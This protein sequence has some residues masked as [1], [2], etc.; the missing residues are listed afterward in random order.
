MAARKTV[1]LVRKI[2]RRTRSSV[3]GPRAAAKTG[4]TLSVKD[5]SV[6]E[7]SQNDLV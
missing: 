1:A 4:T 2:R 7:Y 5:R 3:C 6:V